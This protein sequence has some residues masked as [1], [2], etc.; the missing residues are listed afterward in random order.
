MKQP[1]YLGIR[2]RQALRRAAEILRDEAAVIHR[3]FN[4]DGVILDRAQ[5]RTHDEYL[6]LAADLHRIARERVN[7]EPAK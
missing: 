1:I 6:A 7:K 4:V 3:S 5:K 2:S